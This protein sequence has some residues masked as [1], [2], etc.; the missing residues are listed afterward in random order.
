MNGRPPFPELVVR[1][2]ES[3]D[4]DAIV[5]TFRGLSDTSLYRRFFTLMP[6]P[7]PLVLKHLALV[8]H[9][10]HEALVV[11]DRGRVVA[12]A[13][14][15][16]SPRLVDEAEIAITVDDAW[17]RRGLGTALVR[18]LAASA[19]PHGITTL[20]ANTL[21]ENRPALRLAQRH[22]PDEVQVDGPEAQFRFTLAPTAVA[23]ATADATGRPR[24]R[25]A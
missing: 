1:P 9:H 19:R 7:A 18:A 21:T 4:A 12:V 11:L 16:R 3:G 15:D 14:W 13:H 10:D 2:I 24:V 20:T 17:Q 22:R 6:D 8:D 23:A 25:A 5:A